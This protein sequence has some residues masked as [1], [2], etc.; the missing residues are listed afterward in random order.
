MG[1]TVGKEG[2]GGGGD[3]DKVSVT[4][5]QARKSRDKEGKRKTMTK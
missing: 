4:G 1:M 5:R 2:R 3:E